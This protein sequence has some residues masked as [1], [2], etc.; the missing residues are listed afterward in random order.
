MRL[1]EVPVNTGVR[2]DEVKRS[3]GDHLLPFA[4]VWATEKSAWIGRL[5]RKVVEGVTAPAS[6]T[7]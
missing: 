3:L 2:G 1:V 4:V 7:P 5:Y 6:R